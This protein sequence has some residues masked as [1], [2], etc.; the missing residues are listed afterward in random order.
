MPLLSQICPVCG[1]VA[2][3]ETAD[4][5]VVSV[6]ELIT[7]L[8]R[9]LHSVRVIPKPSFARGMAQLS[10]LIFPLAALFSLAVALIS[11]AGLFWILFAVLAVCSL[12]AVIRKSRGKLG[13]D[14]FN[15]QF[16]E[17]RNDFTYFR[18]KAERSFGKSREVS[19]LVDEIA[20]QID[21]I[22]RERKRASA[23][24]TA[25]WAGI[26]ALIAAL[27]LWGIYGAGK[28]ISAP[29]EE[30][31]I[32]AAAGPDD[33]RNIL[34]AYKATDPESIEGPEMRMSVVNAMLADGKSS[35]ARDFFE[36]YCMGL[37]GDYE[38]A[39][40]IVEHLVTTG[41]GDAAAKFIGHCTAMRYDSDLGKLKKMI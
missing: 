39:R 1:Y 37:R 5:N 36:S 15:R 29:A 13:N 31:R 24:N 20:G 11:Q 28:A 33:W 2:Q 4:E 6:E 10:Y 18:R 7:T 34:E 41:D 3:G 22:E 19:L 32:A 9:I 14:P 17:Y 23:A 21:T 27:G 26:V 25:I 8:E 30:E 12:V 35:Q 16:A 40:Q 38:C